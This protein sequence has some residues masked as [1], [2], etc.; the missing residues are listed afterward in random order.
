MSSLC[1]SLQRVEP[2]PCAGGLRVR[3]REDCCTGKVC[4]MVSK[5]CVV[6]TIQ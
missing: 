6:T 4:F 2:W 1:S 3:Y 5:I